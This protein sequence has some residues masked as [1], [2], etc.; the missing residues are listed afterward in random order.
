MRKL[1]RLLHNEQ[2]NFAVSD[3]NPTPEELKV[4]HKTIKKAQED[5]ENYSFNT[6]V[7]SFMICVNE[8]TSLKCNKRAILTDLVV[9][10]SPFAPHIAEEL[11][12]LLGH[13]ESVTAVTFPVFNEEYLVENTH[14]YPISI[15]GKVRTKLNFA[16]DASKEAIENAV[17]KDETVQKWLDGKSPKRIIVVP[18]R[19]VNIVI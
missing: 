8:L 16:V 14:E 13:Q 1:W 12:H 17:L 10:I 19:I 18:K 7:S 11:W 4:L 2:G 3:D 5:I 9:I 15:N 6:S